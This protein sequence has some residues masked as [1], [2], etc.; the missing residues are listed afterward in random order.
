M[1][2][3]QLRKLIHLF[4]IS[5][6]KENCETFLF[7]CPASHPHSAIWKVNIKQVFQCLDK[8]NAWKFCQNLLFYNKNRWSQMSI[9]SAIDDV[10]K[11]FIREM[12]RDGI[13]KHNHFLDVEGIVKTTQAI[14][15]IIIECNPD[16]NE[17]W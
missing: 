6:F 1:N 7:L 10:E 16:F 3:H 8:L 17:Y 5:Q 15:V 12:G 2:N 13:F 14:T 11:I 4:D 9:T